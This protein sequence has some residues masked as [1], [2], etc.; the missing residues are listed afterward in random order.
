[1]CVCASVC[2]CVCV[3]VCV[4][5]CECVHACMCACVCVHGD[6]SMRWCVYT[7]GIIHTSLHVHVHACIA[8]MSGTYEHF[9]TTYSAENITWTENL[10]PITVKAFKKT[11]GPKVPIPR[12]AKEIFFLFFTPTLLELIVEQTN[13]YA[14]ERMGQERFE[15]WNGR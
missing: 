5:V 8:C 7:I 3:S 13:Q 9:S 1:M 12:S 6:K 10:T 14:A 11:P 2:A 4:C 15:K